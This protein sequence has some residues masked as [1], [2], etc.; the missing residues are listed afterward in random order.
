[1]RTRAIEMM[2]S[3]AALAAMFCAAL[4]GAAQSTPSRA[5]LALSKR[6]HTLAIVDPSTLQV[7]AR[8]GWA[9]ANFSA[10]AG[11]AATDLGRVYEI[12]PTRAAIVGFLASMNW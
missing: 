2:V 3:G 8:D 1:M 9:R 7:I 4:S 10:I 12:F 5:L 6:N 11:E